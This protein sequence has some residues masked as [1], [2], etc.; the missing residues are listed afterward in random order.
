MA[1]DN[2]NNSSFKCYP[3]ECAEGD[4]TNAKAQASK[5]HKLVTIKFEST[6]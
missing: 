2:N 4:I 3:C 1:H 5:T 6:I